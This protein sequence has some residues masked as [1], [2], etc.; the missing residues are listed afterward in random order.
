MYPEMQN[1]F[2]LSNNPAAA[3]D[4]VRCNQPWHWD[5][6]TACTEHERKVLGAEQISLMADIFLSSSSFKGLHHLVQFD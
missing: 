1:H 6:I 3:C 4:S 2:A 5:L